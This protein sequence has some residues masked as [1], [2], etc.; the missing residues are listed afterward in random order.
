MK[1][2]EATTPKTRKVTVTFAEY[3]AI[4]YA[5][6]DMESNIEGE[7]DEYVKPTKEALKHLNKLMKKILGA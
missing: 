7:E 5:I 6:D 3:E 4:V 1:E 2:A